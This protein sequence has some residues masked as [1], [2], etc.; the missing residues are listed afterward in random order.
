MQRL[1]THLPRLL[2]ASIA[3]FYQACI[4][5]VLRFCLLMRATADDASSDVVDT[6][7]NSTSAAACQTTAAPSTT[8]PPL[9]PAQTTASPAAAPDVTPSTTLAGVGGGAGHRTVASSACSA[10]GHAAAAAQSCAHTP[11]KLAHALMFSS[12]AGCQRRVHFAL[13][14][15]CIHCKVHTLACVAR[16]RRL[17]QPSAFMF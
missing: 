16:V 8:N 13:C 9:P 11:R 7:R 15:S 14:T 1:Y 6:C 3:A 12:G 17:L 4:A 10:G 5:A 2:D